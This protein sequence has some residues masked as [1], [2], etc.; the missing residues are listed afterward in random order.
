MFLLFFHYNVLS[1]LFESKKNSLLSVI[2]VRAMAG[3]VMTGKCGE[4]S[5][6]GCLWGPGLRLPGWK[7]VEWA[8]KRVHG[9]LGRILTADPRSSVWFLLL[10]V[11]H[12]FLSLP[13]FPSSLSTRGPQC[14]A[15]KIGG[16]GTLPRILVNNA[17]I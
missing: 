5:H 13:P 7:W 12:L 17:V 10:S 6:S 9:G 4:M 11:I 16:L 15:T 8:G 1:R 3:M 14:N 2:A